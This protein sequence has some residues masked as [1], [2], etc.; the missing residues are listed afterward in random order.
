MDYKALKENPFSEKYSRVRGRAKKRLL[1]ALML[2][3]KTM[4]EPFEAFLITFLKHF[5]GDTLLLKS[6]LMTDHR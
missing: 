4:M 6:L 3:W 2:S 5:S 1:L